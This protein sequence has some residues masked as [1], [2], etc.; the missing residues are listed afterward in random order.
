MPERNYSSLG[1]DAAA[2]ETRAR[3]LDAAS[4]LLRQ[5][6]DPGKVSLDAVA[7]AAGVTRLT[8]YNQFGSR[9]GLLEALFDEI[10]RLG[11]LHRIAAA[12]ALPD[13]YAALDRILEIFCDFWASDHALGRLHAAAAADAEFNTAIAERHERRRKVIGVLVQRLVA[14]GSLGKARGEEVTDM[15]FALSSYAMFE[16]LCK[17]DRKLA[18]VRK[19]LK[20]AFAAALESARIRPARDAT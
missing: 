10:A 20:S 16:M 13:A 6:P 19:M 3:L 4:S 18:T 14:A 11:G 7:K 9:R 8:V 2:A 17:P 5:A 12:M 15:L 1:R